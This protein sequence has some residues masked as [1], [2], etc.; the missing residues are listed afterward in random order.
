MGGPAAANASASMKRVRANAALGSWRKG[1]ARAM[2]SITQALAARML[3]VMTDGACSGRPSMYPALTLRRMS[4]RVGFSKRFGLKRVD[5]AIAQAAAA[6]VDVVD[7]ASDFSYG[8]RSGCGW[9][10]RGQGGASGTG[11]AR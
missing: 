7:T 10:G 5:T 1:Y 11:P 4:G 3:R 9:D 2:N 8:C 6:R